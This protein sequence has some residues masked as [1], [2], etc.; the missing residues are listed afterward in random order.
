[1]FGGDG[2]FCRIQKDHYTFQNPQGYASMTQFFLMTLFHRIY[3]LHLIRD[4]IF[5]WVMTPFSQTYQNI[6]F[7]EHSRMKKEGRALHLLS[8]HMHSRLI[9]CIS[10]QGS[11]TH[12]SSLRQD[13]PGPCRLWWYFFKQTNFNVY[14]LSICCIS[15]LPNQGTWRTKQ[16]TISI[17]DSSDNNSGN[18]S[19]SSNRYTTSPTMRI[20]EWL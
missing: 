15:V 13:P 2:I 6:V 7:D 18:S 12:T 14:M 19:S 5:C 16:C 17:N 11:T 3:C 10:A 1:M 9:R 4:S 8:H 20:V